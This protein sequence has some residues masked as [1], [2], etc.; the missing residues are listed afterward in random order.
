MT[1]RHHPPADLLT[2]YAA[3]TLDL[4]DHIAVATH[5]SAC[6]RCQA[7]AAALEH[8]GGAVLTGLPP[9]PMTDG[10]L[11]RVTAR[12]DEPD[13]HSEHENKD[14]AHPDRQD[15]GR[16][17]RAPLDAVPGLPGFMR[18]YMAAPWIWVAP[19]VRMRPIQLPAASDSRVFLLQSRPRTKMLEHTHTGTELTCVLTGGFR[20]AAGDFGPG[21][22]DW[23]DAE[24]RH[25]V[26]VAPSESCLCL[27]AMRGEVRLR[28]FWGALIQPFIRL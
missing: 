7:M 28:G 27:V 13:R 18:R 8:V 12:L 10:A 22:F 4:G 2:S 26:T 20:H 14:R 25:D 3:G 21:D 23:G 5:L 6:P 1:I 11:A 16:T 15:M 9:M 19:G 17:N 24:V